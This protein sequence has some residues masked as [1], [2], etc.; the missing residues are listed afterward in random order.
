MLVGLPEAIN[1]HVLKAEAEGWA[2]NVPAALQSVFEWLRGVSKP[3]AGVW[4]YRRHLMHLDAGILQHRGA[5]SCCSI[6]T[7]H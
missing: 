7:G 4:T 3:T 1:A 5:V 2:L 6:V